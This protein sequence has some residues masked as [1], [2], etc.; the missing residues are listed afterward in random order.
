MNFVQKSQMRR[1]Y[2]PTLYEHLGSPSVFGGTRVAHAL[3]FCIVLCFWSSSY[4]LCAQVASVFG[5]SILDFSF[6]FL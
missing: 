2:L 1:T 4:V 3:V 6:G 5:L